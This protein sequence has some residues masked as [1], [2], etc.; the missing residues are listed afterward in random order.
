MSLRNP[1]TH[2]GSFRERDTPTLRAT[3]V[4]NAVPP[5]A[6]PGSSLGTL[7]LTIYDAHTLAIVNSRDAVDIKA[8]VN[9]SGALEFQLDSAD[10]AMVTATRKSERRRILL[11][12][13]YDVDHRGSYEME[14]VVENV[15]QVP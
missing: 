7:L 2:L 10:M 14:L 4:D 9:E 8:N 13:T 3:I 5:A 1:D 15:A 12:W 6:I 11:E